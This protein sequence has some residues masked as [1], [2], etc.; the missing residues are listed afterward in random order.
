MKKERILSLLLQKGAHETLKE[1]E[2]KYLIRVLEK[3]NMM[4]TLQLD[5][6]ELKLS[7]NIFFPN[8]FHKI[9]NFLCIAPQLHFPLLHIPI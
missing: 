3:L 8:M 6:M 5:E 7:S 1:N 4:N 2:E 9:K